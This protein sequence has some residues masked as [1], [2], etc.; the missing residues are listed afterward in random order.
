MNRAAAVLPWSIW[1]LSALFVVFNYI[2]QVVPDI[3]AADLI[4][5]FKATDGTLGNIA[6]FYFYAYAILQ[7]PVGLIVD[8]YGTR[9]PLIVAILVAELGI[10]VYR[11]P[12]VGAGMVPSLPIL[13]PCRN[14]QHRGND[15]SRQRG[16]GGGSRECHRMARGGGL[17]GLGGAGPGHPCLFGGSRSAASSQPCRA[18]ATAQADGWPRNQSPSLDQRR[19]CNQH[20]SHI[21]GLWRPLGCELHP[22]SL[23]HERGRRR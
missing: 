22:E 14:D 4:G 1:V 9:R 12:E 20:Q 8:R 13:N 10:L 5:A 23:W 3:I 17:D 18:R 7:I 6:A 16:P 21:C 2:H 15:R 19:L 11:M